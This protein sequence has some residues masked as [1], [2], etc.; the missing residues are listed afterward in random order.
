MMAAVS[1]GAVVVSSEFAHQSERTI[2]IRYI[3]SKYKIQTPV[4]SAVI[5]AKPD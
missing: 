3:K 2:I 4:L 5:G 1:N